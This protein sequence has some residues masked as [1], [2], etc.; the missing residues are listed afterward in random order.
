MGC[1]DD[2]LD[3]PPRAKNMRGNGITTIL[4]HVAQCITFHQTN[5]CTEKLIAEASLKSFYSRLG[6][7]VIKYFATSP[8]FEEAR[9]QFNYESGK[10]KGL[11][12]KNIGL[13]FHQ[14]FLRRDT[15]IHDNRIGFNKNIN[16]FNDL[17]EVP[18]SDDWF[19][20]EYIDAE[21]KKK[22]HETK[23][24]LAGNEME[25]EAKHYVEYLNHDPN[26]LKKIS[27]EIYKFLIN[28]EYIYFFMQIYM[29]W[30]KDGGY[31]SSFRTLIIPRLPCFD[32]LHL[33]QF[34]VYI[35]TE[36]MTHYFVCFNFQNTIIIRSDEGK[37]RFL[38]FY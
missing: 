22:M 1:F 7:K 12:K 37:E 24:Q 5:I 31:T 3:A 11:Q 33:S 6:F 27:I 21:V 35:E 14:T 15:I 38:L 19:P 8:H 26:W 17:N 32:K 4:L 34:K 25:K 18:P 16:L 2:Y 28:R 13:K 30:I 20:Y 10:S 36:T 29:Q 9:K 23:R